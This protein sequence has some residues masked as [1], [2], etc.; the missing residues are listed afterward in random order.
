M[1]KELQILELKEQLA[2]ERIR[3]LESQLII[4]KYE[5]NEIRIL[6]KNTDVRKYDDICK[7]KLNEI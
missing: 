7:A 5:L 6:K 2:I 1:I 3:L 4:Q